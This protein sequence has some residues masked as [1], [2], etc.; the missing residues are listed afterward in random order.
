M[1][2]LLNVTPAVLEDKCEIYR[3]TYE[4]SSGLAG[5]TFLVYQ[6]EVYPLGVAVGG[7]GITEFAYINDGVRD[8]LYFIYSWGSGFFRSHVGVFDFKTKQE[9]ASI[10]FSLQDISFSLSEDGKKL[11]ICQAEIYGENWD[12]EG[13]RIARGDLLYE[14]ILEL[15]FDLAN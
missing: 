4:I 15:N 8:K 13:V 11:G 12:T 9:M 5:V 14:D 1:S 10:P 6:G 3:F 2:Y 7:Y